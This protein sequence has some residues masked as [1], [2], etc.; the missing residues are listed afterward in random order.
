LLEPMFARY[1]VAANSHYAPL[2]DLNA[3]RHR[4]TERSATDLVELLNRE[5][6]VL[7]WLEPTRSRPPVNPLFQG[8]YAFDR[9]ENAR[10]AWY[11]RDFLVGPRRPAPDR[12]PTQ[13]Q[14]DLD[15]LRVR[16]IECRD[17]REFDV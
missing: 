12:V 17:P 6:R 11:A 2:L 15:L 10:L 9:I 3:A 4:L 7:E 14:K 16:L 13:L 5:L 1:G 8:A